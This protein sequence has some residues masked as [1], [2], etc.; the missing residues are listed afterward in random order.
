LVKEG[1]NGPIYCTPAT[2]DL[3]QVLLLDSGFIQEADVAFVNKRRAAQGLPY[4]KP[5][6]TV[7]DANNVFPLLREVPYG[8]ITQIDEDISFQ[9]TDTG[10]ILGSAAVQRG[11]Q[12][13][14]YNF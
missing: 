9:Y 1:F 7:A 8:E 14:P 4:I 12:R 13:N 10:P 2:A 5:L 11:R 3:V 6:Y